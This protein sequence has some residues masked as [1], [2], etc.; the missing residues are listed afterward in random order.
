MPNT[1]VPKEQ[2]GQLSQLKRPFAECQKMPASSLKS[3]TSARLVSPNDQPK[4]K[5]VRFEKAQSCPDSKITDSS[6]GNV[7]MPP[8]TLESSKAFCH[9]IPPPPF[10]EDS[11]CSAGLH[12]AKMPKAQRRKS[13]PPLTSDESIS[14]L[15]ARL[16]IMEARIKKAVKAEL[17]LL[18]KSKKIRL[19]REAYQKQYQQFASGL[20]KLIKAKYGKDKEL[21]TMTIPPVFGS[22][23]SKCID[24]TATEDQYKK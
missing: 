5:L 6:S 21:R 8:S 11:S 24:L 23:Q 2:T 14:E 22:T 10:L 17:S 15:Q 4:L 16:E 1:F 13:P 12:S 9:H 18:N 3:S 20:K 19:A 7:T